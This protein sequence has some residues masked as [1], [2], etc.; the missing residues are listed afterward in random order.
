MTFAGTGCAR[1]IGIK[2]AAVFIP[3]PPHPWIPR[4]KYSNRGTINRLGN[5]HWTGINGGHTYSVLDKY[6]KLL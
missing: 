1:L 2:I 6:G 4:A 5:V 3:R